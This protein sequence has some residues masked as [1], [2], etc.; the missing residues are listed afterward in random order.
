M[1][2]MSFLYVAPGYKTLHPICQ[3]NVTSCQVWFVS[4]PMHCMGPYLRIRTRVQ[5]VPAR[6]YPYTLAGPRRRTRV[7]ARSWSGT[8]EQEIA[9]LDAPVY[10]WMLLWYICTEKDVEESWQAGSSTGRVH[11]FL[12]R[13][14][15]GGYG[16]SFHDLSTSKRMASQHGPMCINTG[17][18]AFQFQCRSTFCFRETK[19][20]VSAMK[21]HIY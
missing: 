19:Q 18:G 1:F 5:L 2:K 15:V 4:L 3:R 10:G 13:L 6:G 8:N 14:P 7:C 17:Y 16:V 9:S 21:H 20:D 12:L 11:A